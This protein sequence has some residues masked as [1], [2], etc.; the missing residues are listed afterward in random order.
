MA[1]SK[2]VMRQV[3]WHSLGSTV[4]GVSHRDSHE[5]SPTLGGGTQVD[6]FTKGFITGTIT[7]H[8]QRRKGGGQGDPDPVV[9]TCISYFEGV[10][11]SRTTLSI[12]RPGKGCR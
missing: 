12:D 1:G 5:I 4:L 6:D 3:W 11:K 8:S 9:L 10:A 2:G 7:K